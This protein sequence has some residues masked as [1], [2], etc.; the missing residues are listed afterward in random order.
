M[1]GARALYDSTAVIVGRNLLRVRRAPDLVIIVAVQPILFILLFGYVFGSAIEVH[2]GSYREFLMAGI[3]TQTV[4]FGSSLAGIGM[5]DDLE[6]GLIDRFRSLPIARAS[7]LIARVASQLVTSL[8]AIITMVICGLLV[9]WR[10]RNGL[11]DASLA[12]GL[13]LLLGQGMSWV[14]VAIGCLVR[15]TEVAQTACF[16]WMFPFAFVSNAF[17]PVQGMSTPLRVLAEWNPVSAVTTTLRGL[18]G[19]VTAL[20]STWAS[21]HAAGVAVGWCLALICVF[22]PLSVRIYQWRAEH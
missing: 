4:I 22:L 5:A 6:H 1:T 2:G 18:F 15:S 19:N 3:F 16:V 21:V 20:P 9:G 12:F 11:I 17:V 10:A 7:I 14:S 8:I 13:L